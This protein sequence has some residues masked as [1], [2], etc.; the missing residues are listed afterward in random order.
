LFGLLKVLKIH[1]FG[2][3]LYFFGFKGL[4]DEKGFLEL[5]FTSLFRLSK[6]EKDQVIFVIKLIKI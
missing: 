3:I 1:P 5:S 2:I 6:N 4:D